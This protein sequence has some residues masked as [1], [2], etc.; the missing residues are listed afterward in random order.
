MSGPNKCEK[1]Y[2]PNDGR[3]DDRT[4]EWTAEGC[5]SIEDKDLEMYHQQYLFLLIYF[6]GPTIPF[7][8]PFQPTTTTWNASWLA[9]V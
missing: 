2:R 6:F 9:I 3:T 8:I 1:F 4:D 7:R 5:D